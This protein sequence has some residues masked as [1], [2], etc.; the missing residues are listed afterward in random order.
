M[1]AALSSLLAA[2]A[3]FDAVFG[4]FVLA[5]VVLSW[6]T[7][8]WAVRRDRAGREAWARR[9]ME[10]RRSRDETIA[11]GHRPPG[12]TGRGPDGDVTR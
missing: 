10:R 5:M 12:D 1:S 8:R 9:T 4:L 7:L 2:S 6:V 11:N 3:A